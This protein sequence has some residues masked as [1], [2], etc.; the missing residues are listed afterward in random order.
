MTKNNKHF[1]SLSFVSIILFYFM[2]LVTLLP[3]SSCGGSSSAEGAATPTDTLT[4]TDNTDD[5]STTEE[6][7]SINGSVQKGPFILGTNVTIYKLDSKLRQTG[8]SYTTSTSDNLGNFEFSGKFKKNSFIE[9]ITSG[10]YFDEITGA[11]SD[12]TLTLRTIGKISNNNSININILT[13]I[14]AERLRY[15]IQNGSDFEDAQTQA[16]QEILATFGINESLDNFQSLDITSSNGNGGAALLAIS[17]TM[18]QMAHTNASANGS[19]VA[20]LSSSLANII[21]DVKT[22]GT[23]NSVT[24]QNRITQS[25]EKLDW[26]LVEIN[27]KTRYDSMG[28]SLTIPNIRNYSNN[29]W[30]TI[31]QEQSILGMA[32]YT[33]D[34]Y[35]FKA[36]NVFKKINLITLSNT[37][38]NNLP[39]N[40]TDINSIKPILINSKIYL[41]N[42][43]A[44]SNNQMWEYDINSSIWTQK[45]SSN[46]NHDYATNSIAYDGKIYVFGGHNT[47]I[48]EYYNPENNTWTNIEPLNGNIVSSVTSS[49][50][51]NQNI[52]LQLTLGQESPAIYIY[53]PISNSYSL[54]QIDNN[55]LANM[56]KQQIIGIFNGTIYVRYGDVLMFDYVWQYDVESNTWNQCTIF[57]TLNTNFVLGISRPISQYTLNGKMFWHT[58]LGGIFSYDPSKE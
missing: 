46:A 11:L 3:I 2:M 13:S 47:T 49:I 4:P 26:G 15:L 25:R 51:Y 54:F 28:L 24:Y 7:L 56:I 29:T 32:C 36:P 55:N 50:I 52:Y 5:S 27:L 21:T 39:F 23:L 53:N 16:E 20:E 9:I 17:A 43:V 14:E 33:S 42:Y 18:L 57:N 37:S 12:S 40:L 38:L 35:I 34:C 22:D 19:V 45:A 48:S 6:D 58:Y 44:N 31:S 8:E 41:V 30:S 1:L 10:Y